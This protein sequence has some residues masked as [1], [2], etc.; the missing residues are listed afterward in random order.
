MGSPQSHH[1]RA[2][3]LLMTTSSECVVLDASVVSILFNEADD[4]RYHYYQERLAGRRALLSF[5]TVEELLYWRYAR[6]W[7][8]AR[9]LRLRDR[10]A[11]YEIVWPD[12]VL[13]HLSARLRSDLREMGRTL[14]VADAW[15]AATAL[16][17]E[18]PLASDDRDFVGIPGL[19]LIQPR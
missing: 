18:C 3:R 9:A 8:E 12:Q 7:G 5:Q 6:A 15:I 10:I 4:R 1:P 13:V 2:P 11:E 16:M 19:P 17:R 14:D